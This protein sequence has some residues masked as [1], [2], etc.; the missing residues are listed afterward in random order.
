MLEGREAL[1]QGPDKSVG[2]HHGH[3]EE[4]VLDSACGMG[5]PWGSVYRLGGQA[6]DS[7]PAGRDLGVLVG[8]KL[9]LSQQCVLATRGANRTWGCVKASTETRRGKG[10]LLFC[11]AWCDLTWSTES[12]EG[13]TT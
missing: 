10:V 3:E 8:S 2:A 13:A 4:Q 1:R 11:S 9:H 6:L 7:R 12:S 5:Q